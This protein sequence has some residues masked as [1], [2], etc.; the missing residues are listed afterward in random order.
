MT[1][2][3]SRARYDDVYNERI[4]GRAFVEDKAYYEQSRERYWRSLVQFAKHRPADGASLLDIGGGQFAILT[5]QLFGYQ[6]TAADAVSDA[7]ADIHAAGLEFLLLNLMDEDYDTSQQ[8]DVISILEVIE[9]IPIP[10]YL[11]LGRLAKMLKPGGVLFMTTPNGFR[12]RNVLY[13]LANKRVLDHFRY[14]DDNEP[15]GHMHEYTLPQL[16]WQA[17]RAGL[18]VLLA[19]QTMSGWK[20]A[21]KG[22]AAMRALTSPAQ[23]VPHLRESLI[24]TLKKP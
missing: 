23:L 2:T 1:Q 10:P 9:H 12:L 6:A 4:L 16:L 24:M 7:E 3:V 20:G 15:M 13:M 19:E 14:N 11:I 18:E 22:A 5:Q 21:S 17:E 8:F